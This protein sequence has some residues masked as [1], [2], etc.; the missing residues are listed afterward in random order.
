VLCTERLADAAV[1]QQSSRRVG[2]VVYSRS[3]SIVNGARVVGT[4][5]VLGQ[6]WRTQRDDDT[7]LAVPVPI[8]ALVARARSD[9][10]VAKHFSPN[11]IRSSKK[12]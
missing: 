1:R 11:T 2:Y 4:G 9:D 5:S 6:F 12:R 3:T 7:V 10:A 8:E